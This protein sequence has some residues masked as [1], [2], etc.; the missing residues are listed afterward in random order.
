MSA[1][2]VEPAVDN[3][4]AVE[5]AVDDERALEQEF[6]TPPTQTRE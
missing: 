1:E 4:P 5:P 3:E 2:P 6:L